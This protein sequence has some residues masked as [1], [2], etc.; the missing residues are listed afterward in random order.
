VPIAIRRFYEQDLWIP[1]TFLPT[2]PDLHHGLLSVLPGEGSG[3]EEICRLTR[4]W[5]T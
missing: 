5:A 1:Q 3:D 4:A 2:N